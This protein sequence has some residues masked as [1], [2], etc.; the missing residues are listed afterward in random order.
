MSPVTTPT[1]NEIRNKLSE[2]GDLARVHLV[3]GPVVPRLA[4]RD[5]EREPDG[6]RDEEEVEDR[7]DPE[8]HPREFDRSHGCRFSVMPRTL[9]G[10]IRTGA[11]RSSLVRLPVRSGH[12]AATV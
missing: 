1:A 10:G 11:V 4:D 7:R 12:Y 8:L 9:Y 6:D 5:V 3:P 2:E